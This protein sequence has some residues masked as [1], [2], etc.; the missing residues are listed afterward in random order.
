MHSETFRILTRYD[1]SYS[2]HFAHMYPPAD[3]NEMGVQSVQ[4][5][6]I[7][8]RRGASEVRKTSTMSHMFSIHTVAK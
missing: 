5:K 6:K 2:T 4:M 7:R 3:Q 8:Y 1:N